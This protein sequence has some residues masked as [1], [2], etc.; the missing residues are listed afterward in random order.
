MPTKKIRPGML[1]VTPDKDWIF[2][3]WPASEADANRVAKEVIKRCK[4][5]DS[6][7]RRMVGS[8]GAFNRVA[9]FHLWHK[10]KGPDAKPKWFEMPEP[11]QD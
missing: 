1:K 8:F 3:N 5:F 2:G 4:N 7:N 6:F 9:A 11:N 10:L